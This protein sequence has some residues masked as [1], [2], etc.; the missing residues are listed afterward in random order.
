MEAGQKMCKWE[1]IR[2]EII[3]EREEEWQKLLCSKSEF[4]KEKK[5][6]VRSKKPQ[7]QQQDTGL[8][9]LRRSSRNTKPKSFKEDD[10]P[11]R[12]H[13]RLFE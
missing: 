5:K 4:D 12:F 6:K 9:I 13:N 1:R 11:G 3:A 10:I 2:E 8:H 7:K